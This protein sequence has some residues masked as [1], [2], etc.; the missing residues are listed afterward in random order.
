MPVRV[1]SLSA[2]AD[3]RGHSYAVPLAI[4]A[5]KECHIATIRPGA[6]RGNHYHTQRHELLVVLHSDRW[7]LLWDEGEGTAVESRSFEGTGAVLMDADP[8][9]AHAVRND[10]ASE[11][12]I[13]SLGDVPSTDT[14]PRILARPLTRLAGI[15]GCPEGWIAVTRDG[16]TL[17]VRILRSDEELAALFRD[18]AVAAIDVPIGLPESGP[19]SCDHHARRF[20]GRRGSSVFPAPLRALL[21]LSDYAEA[22]RVSRELQKRGISKQAFAIVPKVAQIDRLLQ[23]H[24]ELRP[25][26]YEVHPEVSFA[27]W[28]ASPLADSKHTREGAALRRA[29]VS[30]H[31]GSVPD[32][33]RGA[34]END[35]LDAMAALWTAER[36]HAGRA[37][38]LGDAHV[39]VT[40][41]PMRIV[42]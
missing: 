1:H 29:L 39:D 33:P 13:V 35:L 25:R 34:S 3:A 36:I 14:H 17:E 11:L 23:R 21:G 5:V 27:M 28:S 41:L 40:G 6:I 15:D 38:S 30:A 16:M 24:R 4:A 42:V 8:L 20:L 12:Q 2:S 26:V 7:T 19:R 9:C 10:G 32:V 31:F 37:H 22:N 18:C